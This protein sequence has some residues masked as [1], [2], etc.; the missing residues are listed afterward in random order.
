MIHLEFASPDINRFHDLARTRTGIGILHDDT[1][2][3]PRRTLRFSELLEPHIG[4]RHEL[5]GVARL[6]GVVW[7]SCAL[8]RGSGRKG[9]TVE[10]G[11]ALHRLE[12]AIA[13]GLRAAVLSSIVGAGLRVDLEPAVLVIDAGG[14]VRQATAASVARVAELGSALGARL[15]T[16]IAAVVAS[17]RSMRGEAS[18]GLVSYVRTRDRDGAWLTIR[19]AQLSGIG[20]NDGDV[21]V[22][23]R[24]ADEADLLTLLID[25]YGLTAREREVVRAVVVGAGTAEI[26]STMGISAYTVQDHLKAA[27]AKT[28]VSN[29]R[30]LAAV[31][32]RSSSSRR[33]PRAQLILGQAPDHD[34]PESWDCRFRC[35]GAR[36][37]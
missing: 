7:G 1:G 5:R 22:T 35:S 20:P 12:V 31:A 32:H 10:E 23:I 16:P 29:R 3:D 19:A 11:L 37:G 26:A 13:T 8:Y 25:A 24:R 4:I 18:D 2:G 14:E 21:A 36:S 27:F 6:G 17:A 9:F 34:I 33:A 15:P 30:E 28:G